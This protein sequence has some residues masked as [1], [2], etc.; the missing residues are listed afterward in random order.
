[1][2]FVIASF[3]S[4][5]NLPT[6]LILERMSVAFSRSSFVAISRAFAADCALLTCALT[7]ASSFVSICM[8]ILCAYNPYDQ[9]RPDIIFYYFSTWRVLLSFQAFA[10]SLVRTFLR[11][12]FLLICV[13]SLQYYRQQI[14]RPE[15]A[16]KYQ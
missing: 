3:F 9:D 14:Y 10:Y 5:I 7:V 11:L 6:L 8:I 4:F 2:G 13:Y 1:M 12:L 15:C 16:D